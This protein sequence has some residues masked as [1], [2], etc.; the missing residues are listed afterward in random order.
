MLIVMHKNATA[1]QIQAVADKIRELGLTPH[2][3]PGSQRTAIGVTGNQGPL[4]SEIFELLPGVAQAIPVSQPFK[5]AA[6][7]RA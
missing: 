7:A 2:T 5:L 3:I 6:Q 4:P 1:G